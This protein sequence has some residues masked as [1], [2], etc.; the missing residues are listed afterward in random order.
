[1]INIIL[2]IYI[3]LGFIIL[4]KKKK[5]RPIAKQIYI[6]NTSLPELLL[7][8]LLYNYLENS[9]KEYFIIT[10]NVDDCFYKA[11]FPPNRIFRPQGSYK[12]L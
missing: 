12:I 11:G 1:M 4:K 9:N 3:H 7:Y 5:N 10:T 2:E 6:A 8:K